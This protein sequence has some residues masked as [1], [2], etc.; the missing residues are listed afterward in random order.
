MTFDLKKKLLLQ[1]L[2]SY[3]LIITNTWL[4]YLSI[5]NHTVDLLNPNR[6]FLRRVHTESTRHESTRMSHETHDSICEVTWIPL[7]ARVLGTP[8]NPYTPM[9]EGS[10]KDKISCRKKSHEVKIPEEKIPEEKI[11]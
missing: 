6:Y 9:R 10:W 11:Q 2:N 4:L 7:C 5:P 3:K 1:T 8:W